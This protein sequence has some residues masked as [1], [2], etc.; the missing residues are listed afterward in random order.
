MRKEDTFHHL[1][2]QEWQVPDVS[3]TEQALSHFPL[4]MKVKKDTVRLEDAPKGSVKISQEGKPV[5]FAYQSSP[6]SAPVD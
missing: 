4:K 5:S 1:P 6:C 2:L 3:F